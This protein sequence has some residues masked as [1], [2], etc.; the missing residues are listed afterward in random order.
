M[1]K[2][3]KRGP[4]SEEPV[5][6]ESV[7]EEV[8]EAG[9]EAANAQAETEPVVK[10][11]VSAEPAEVAGEADS[12]EDAD[13][14]DIVALAQSKMEEYKDTLQ[15]VQAEFDNYRKRNA[16]AVKQARAEGVNETI[17]QMLP[18][19]DTVEIAIGMIND[20]A[21]K[22]GVELIRKKFAEV[23]SH[24]GVEEIEAQGAEFD[25]ALHNAVMQVEDAENSG[26]VVEVLRK[27]YRRNGKVIRYAMV[28]VAN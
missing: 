15:R 13:D 12:A 18:V 4:E 9:N 6:A 26:K 3:N 24:Y 16:E 27:G 10:E 22:A 11:G 8:A 25:P 1:N 7:N 20:E 14:I 28:K 2:K 5:G 21:T 19:L 17:L 23:F